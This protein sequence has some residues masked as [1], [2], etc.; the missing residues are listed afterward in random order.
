LRR[1]KRNGCRSGALGLKDKLKRLER[2][3]REEMISIPQKD[4]TVKRF[5]KREVRAAYKN[6]CDRLGRGEDAPEEHP[7]LEAA[8]N[9]S[10]PA[11]SESSYSVDEG[12]LEP[13]E[14]LS[15]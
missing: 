2:A 12:W 7:L 14:D 11:W 13:V 1:P 5:P 6:L 3:R 10:D 4:G 9:S 15:E 8:R